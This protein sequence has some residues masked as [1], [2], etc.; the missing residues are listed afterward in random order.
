MA[1]VVG[2]IT[3]CVA[4]IGDTKVIILAKLASDWTVVV[5]V[6]VI[7]C[8]HRHNQLLVIAAMATDRAAEIYR[9]ART[10]RDSVRDWGSVADRCEEGNAA[11]EVRLT[12]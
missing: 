10:F 4:T 8:R 11:K 1:A 7:R 2:T 5:V 3:D 9:F 6:V 12:D